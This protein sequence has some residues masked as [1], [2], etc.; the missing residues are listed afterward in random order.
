VPSTL[1]TAINS[2]TVPIIECVGTLPRKEG[3]ITSGRNEPFA[4]GDQQPG[5]RFRDL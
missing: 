2:P 3:G 5:A 4:M 1:A